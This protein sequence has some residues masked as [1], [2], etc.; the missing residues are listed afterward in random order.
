MLQEQ[1]WTLG[2]QTCRVTP[3]FTDRFDGDLSH[4]TDM[5]L[6]SKWSIRDGHLFGEFRPGGST[7]WLKP[8]FDGDII[9]SFDIESIAP[10]KEDWPDFGVPID[11]IPADQLAQGPNNLNLFF[12]CSGPN[13][14]N[15]LD[16][17]PQLMEEATG[18]NQQSDDQYRGYFF[19]FTYLWARLRRLPKYE[20]CSDRQDVRS[21][22]GR[23]YRIQ[24]IRRGNRLRYFLDGQLIH[25]HQ[26]DRPHTRG[27]M[28]ICIWR[29]FVK[30][31][32]VR[33]L[34]I[35]DRDL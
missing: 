5:G 4:W 6:G 28:G 12:L 35:L 8:V 7:I 16:C 17:Y 20:L 14:E 31:S 32:D 3:L 27:Q 26:D 15:M 13:G 33:V 30:V 22:A 25:D 34:R 23:V 18:P 9:M 19:T 21:Q 11:K 10:R 2:E 1:S 29:N 24:A